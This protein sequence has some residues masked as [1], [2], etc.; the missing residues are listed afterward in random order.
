[1]ELIEL[2]QE[3]SKVASEELAKKISHDFSYDLVIFIA[4]GS[5]T[6]GKELADYNNTEL[7][8]IKVARKGNFIKEKLKIFLNI[9]PKGIKNILRNI[10]INSNVHDKMPKRK[11]SFE[12]NIWKRFINARKIIIV[13]DS[14]D[15]G[16]SMKQCKET[17]EKFFK[18]SEIKVAALNVFSKSEKIIKVD[19]YL[20]KDKLLQGPWSN[21]S[22]DNKKFIQ[23]YEKFKEEYK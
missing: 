19:Y 11:I 12:E 23:L 13:D 14:V 15:T 6:I 20:Y 21:D 17:V 1:M 16:H 22:K 9:L 7:I 10:E 8:E 4:K 2:S 3:S 5:Y 18:N